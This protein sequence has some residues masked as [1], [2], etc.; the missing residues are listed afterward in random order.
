[1]S[2]YS[3][4]KGCSTEAAEPEA[5]AQQAASYGV[6]E[7]VLAG[8][9]D[10]QPPLGFDA[11]ELV[12]GLWSALGSSVEGQF[13]S[14]ADW[15]RARLEMWHA[16][17][18]VRSGRPTANQWAAMQRGLD[19]LLISPAVK[20]RAGIELRKHAADA[21]EAAA[22]SMIGRYRQSLKPV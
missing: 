11:H 6:A 4:P 7:P 14:T 5:Q 10:G 21:D 8:Q 2:T 19:E 15:E 9:A 16:D 22:T 1:M 20:R 3:A 18:L 13:Y 17:K 12:A